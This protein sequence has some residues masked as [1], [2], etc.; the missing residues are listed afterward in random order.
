MTP[1]SAE[2]RQDDG[3]V[4]VTTLRGRD[5]RR[6][7][8]V[9]GRAF[10]AYPESTHLLPDESRRRRVLPRY[11]G[12]DMIDAAKFGWLL[13]AT[14]DGHIVGAAA[15]L[16]PSAYPIPARRQVR[17]LVEMVPVVPWALGAAAEARRGQHANRQHH[18]G[19]PPHFYLRAIGIDP[20]MQ[21]RG[22][23]TALMHSVIDQ[24]DRYGVG[25]FLTT[26][27]AENAA[28]YE[29]LGFSIAVQYKP[30]PTWPNVWALWREPQ[31]PN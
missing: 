20:A 28:W 12:S 6:A 11:L 27:T 26:A 15:W 10:W 8:P 13:G 3:I 18:R 24:A 17:Q 1:P 30:T 31:T 5:V 25:C 22:I 2:R 14:V 4:K 29:H 21:G 7:I 9:M 23:G 19:R 16:P